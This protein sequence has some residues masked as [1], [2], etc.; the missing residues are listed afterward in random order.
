MAKSENQ[1]AVSTA[2]CLVVSYPAQGHINPMLQFSKR[3]QYKGIKV[4]VVTTRFI[5][6]TIHKPSSSNSNITF[7]TISDGYDEGRDPQAVS[8]DVY[9]DRFRKVGSQTLT[10]LVEKLNGSGCPVDCIVYI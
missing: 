6:N 8:I 5:Y 10:D 2:H 3:L 9:L 1:L 4:T 7:E